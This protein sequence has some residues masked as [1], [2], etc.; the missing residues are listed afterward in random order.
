[1]SGRGK[2]LGKGLGMRAARSRADLEFNEEETGPIDLSTEEDPSEI[3]DELLTKLIS[4]VAEQNFDEEEEYN[5]DDEDLDEP[6]VGRPISVLQILQAADEEQQKE[7]I[8]LLRTCRHGTI[9]TSGVDY[10][11]CGYYFVRN[12][13]HPE[14]SFDPSKL[15]DWDT[16]ELVPAE[17]EYGYGLPAFLADTPYVMNYR[18]PQEH[19]R[20][21]CTIDPATLC[22][23]V[24]KARE[25]ILSAIR[26]RP[27]MLEGSGVE[28]AK[29]IVEFAKDDLKSHASCLLYITIPLDFDLDE[30]IAD[31][32]FDEHYVYIR[33][34]QPPR[35]KG[36]NE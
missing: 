24:A 29:K 6:E 10:R 15:E 3:E 9:V 35:S 2:G 5:D 13:T 27:Q 14:T 21:D 26:E 20:L 11:G 33:P 30:K 36:A 23:S 25:L 19:V 8:Q 1:M 22:E 7:L 31:Y 17:G 12:K 18:S 28:N 16:L 34:P 32:F 4:E